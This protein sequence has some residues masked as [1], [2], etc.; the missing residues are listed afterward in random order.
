MAKKNEKSTD[1]MA[2]ARNGARKTKRPY[3]R[4]QLIVYGRVADLTGSKTA[5]GFDSGHKKTGPL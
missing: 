1:T 4:P 2:S 5:S 3:H